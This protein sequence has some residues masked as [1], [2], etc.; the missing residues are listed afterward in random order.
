[1]KK[2]YPQPEVHYTVDW[3]DEGDP[4]GYMDVT[5]DEPR[6]GDILS[7]DNGFVRVWTRNDSTNTCTKIEIE[8][9]TVETGQA[10]D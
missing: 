9:Q 4:V 5:I 2:T 3:N 8:L 10:D 1:M 7:Y 6:E